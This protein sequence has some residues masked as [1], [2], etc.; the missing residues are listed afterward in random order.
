MSLH[1]SGEIGEK[2]SS[3]ETRGKASGEIGE[4]STG[5]NQGDRSGELRRI[6]MFE[7]APGPQGASVLKQT[8][9][10]ERFDNKPVHTLLDFGENGRLEVYGRGAAATTHDIWWLGRVGDAS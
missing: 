4:K 7:K 6:E 1:R 10:R 9:E 5:E 2:S 3:G 8:E